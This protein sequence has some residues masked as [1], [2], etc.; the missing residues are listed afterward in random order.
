MS[1]ICY[2]NLSIGYEGLYEIVNILR[3]TFSNVLPW[4]K[5]ILVKCIADSQTANKSTVAGVLAGSLTSTKVD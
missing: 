5:T 4:M 1:Y 2:T 3:L